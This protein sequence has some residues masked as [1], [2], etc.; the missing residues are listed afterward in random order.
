[1]C[2][3]TLAEA[4]TRLGDPRIALQVLEV[5]E[6]IAT[7]RADPIRL[8]LVWHG[9]AQACEYLGEVDRAMPLYER[10]ASAGET[11]QIPFR[12]SSSRRGLAA[13][14]LV[15]GEYL[16][17]LRQ[18]ARAANHAHAARLHSELASALIGA[19][20]AAH[21]GALAAPDDIGC[22][23]AHACGRER[24]LNIANATADMAPLVTLLGDLPRSGPMETDALALA[25][26]QRWLM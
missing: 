10:A 19:A 4:E 1:M 14:A 7:R 21:A 12:A 9:Q 8:A 2:R 23:L 5:A 25:R 17:A 15:R 24:E 20:A 11:L 6:V 13:L 22:L 16:T 3:F 18:Y 26:V